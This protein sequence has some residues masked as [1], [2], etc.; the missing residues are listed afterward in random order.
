MKLIIAIVQKE[1]ANRLQHTFVKENIRA[2]K[3][4]TT[5]GFLSQGNT[6]FL[7]GI[8]DDH[9][10]EVLQII[11]EESKARE[12]YMNSNMVVT[13]FDMNSQP[14]KITVGGATCFVLPVEA[15]KQF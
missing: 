14:I 13:G 10:K 2:T 4:A 11:K 1:D 8:D 9:V 5:G 6:T 7:I 15:F 12:E 3:L